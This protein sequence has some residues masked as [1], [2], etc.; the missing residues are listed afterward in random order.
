M[1][2][3]VIYMGS[4]IRSKVGF[5]SRR[6]R[7][8]GWLYQPKGIKRPPL[9]LMAPG[10]AAEKTFGLEGYAEAYA[11][12]GYAV[13]LFDYRNHGDSEGMPRNLVRAS[14]QLQDWEAALARVKRL[15]NINTE[16]IILWGTSLS[17]GHVLVTAARHPEVAAVVCHAPF[18]DGF[19]TL[20]GRKVEDILKSVGAGIIDAI[21]A[22]GG[23][24]CTIPVVGAP[25][26]FACLNQPGAAEAYISMIPK[27]SKW[28]NNCPASIFLTLPWYR[29]INFAAEIKCPVLVVKA[30]EDNIV[31]VVAIDTTLAKIKQGRLL[32]IAGGHFDFYQGEIFTALYQQELSFLTEYG[33]KNVNAGTERVK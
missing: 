30:R 23:V 4:F 14:R 29:P 1:K 28:V 2:V 27:V 25:G 21:L 26:T 24:R 22:L 11:Q 7:C 15:P 10:L 9:V 8:A 6:T 18:T 19:T 33:M 32:E 5:Q 17:G 3:K 12:D 31:S 16:K 20:A 13:Y